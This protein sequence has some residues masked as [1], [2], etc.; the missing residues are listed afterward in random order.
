MSD[1]LTRKELRA[2]DAFQRLGSGARDWLQAHQTRIAAIIVGLLVLGGIVGL[3]HYFSERKHGQASHSLGAAFEILSR[4]LESDAGLDADRKAKAFKDA[5]ARDKAALAEFQTVADKY[6]NSDS[7][8]TARLA[9][10][11]TQLRLKAYDDALAAFDAYLKVAPEKSPHRATAIEGKGYA[12]ELKG[13]LEQAMKTF[14]ELANVKTDVYLTDMGNYHR[15]RLLD[16]QGKKEEAA[17]LFDEVKTRSPSTEAGRLS[18]S[19]LALLA[20][21]GIKPPA[22]P[23]PPAAP[24]AVAA[25]VDAG[26]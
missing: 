25:G 17:K 3:V 18:T 21:Q 16:S 4:P 1:K 14:E 19:R 13:D 20:A 10:A 26:S 12:Y 2:P 15:A 6:G 5:A 24:A 8:V 7:G 11:Q 9:I 23:P 22:P